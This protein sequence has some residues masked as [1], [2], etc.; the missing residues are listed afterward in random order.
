MVQHEN[1]LREKRLGWIVTLNGFLF[2][3]LSFA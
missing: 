3:G 2:T 1:S